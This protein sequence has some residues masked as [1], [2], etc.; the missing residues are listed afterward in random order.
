MLLLVHP[1]A[2]GL[3][4]RALG[5]KSTARMFLVDP[6]HSLAAHSH[7]AVTH[8]ARVSQGVKSKAGK[9]VVSVVH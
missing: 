6:W 2:G 5:S 8:P 9:L 7:V 4:S 1:P 3:S